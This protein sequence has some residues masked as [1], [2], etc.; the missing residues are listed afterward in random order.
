MVPHFRI[1]RHR[2]GSL[3]RRRWYVPVTVGGV[4]I[5]GIFPPFFL[6]ERTFPIAPVWLHTG[7][8]SCARYTFHNRVRGSE[9]LRSVHTGKMTEMS[10][11]HPNMAAHLAGKI[12][13]TDIQMKPR[14]KGDRHLPLRLPKSFRCQRQLPALAAVS[15]QC[16]KLNASPKRSADRK[17][18]RGGETGDSPSAFLI[19]PIKALRK[20][21][22]DPLYRNP[23]SI[24]TWARP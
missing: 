17:T 10:C 19:K 23:T 14:H 22:P 5:S 4:L 13:T 6:T 12:A 3:R 2:S 24:R 7:F 11:S 15:R 9:A 20:F 8:V 16:V 21:F 1:F 18:T